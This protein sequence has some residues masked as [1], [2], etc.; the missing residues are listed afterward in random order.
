MNGQT[1]TY[2]RPYRRG[3]FQLVDTK[4]EG[5]YWQSREGLRVRIASGEVT[6]MRAQS[7]ARAWTLALAML[8]ERIAAQ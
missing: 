1:K 4:T 2:R 6:S 8:F 7:A 3:D 5:T